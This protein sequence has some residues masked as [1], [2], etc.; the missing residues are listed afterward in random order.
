MRRFIA[1]GLVVV[2]TASC[3]AGVRWERA[4]VTSAERQRDETEC[5]ARASR[6]S[7]I[8]TAETA[9]LAYSTPVDA[10]RVAV[11]PYDTALFD[12]CMQARGY[13]RIA[14]GRPA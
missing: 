4:G 10:Q 9:G 5:A 3:A 11:R 8:P 7:T 2:G 1:L 12:Q 14:A 6:E 13:Q